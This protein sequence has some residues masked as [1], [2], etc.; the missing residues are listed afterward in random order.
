MKESFLH[1]L[2]RW[3]RFE[4]TSLF[5]TDG[6]TL[7]ILHPGEW[8]KHAGPDFFNA[9]V[10]IGNTLWAG[11]VELHVKSSEWNNHRHSDDP[12]YDTVILHVVLEEDVPIYRSNRERIP[13]LELVNRIPSG[14]LSKYQRLEKQRSWIPCQNEYMQVPAIVRTGWHERML[15]ERLEEKTAHI[16][17]ILEETNHDW[18]ETF[19]R[20]LA[21]SFGLKVNAEPFEMLARSLPF[22]VIGKHKHQLSQIEALLFGQAGMLNKEFE[23]KHPRILARE[24]Q[25]LRHKY[26]LT[27]MNESAWKFLR[28]RPANF[29]SIRLAQ[30]AV[31][32]HNANNLL[33]NILETKDIKELEKILDVQL[34]GYWLDHFVFDKESKASSKSLGRDYVHL[35]IINAVVPFIFYWGKVKKHDPFENHALRL[36]EQMPPE[37]NSILREWEAIGIKAENSFQ[38]QALIHLKTRFCDQKRC[39]ECAVGNAILK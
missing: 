38:S 33:S 9:R 2:W 13:C 8:N 17:R 6:Q 21:R 3:R 36:L 11:N 31:L 34:G 18:Q 15:V 22:K 5:T 25:F 10:K 20:V 26:K 12:A 30:F 39:L 28:L 37:S 19:Y 14:I 16:A 29:P 35:L 1:F 7:E 27:P 23:D 24:Y 32:L 4:A